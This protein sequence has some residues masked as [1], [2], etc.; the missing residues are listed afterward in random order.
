MDN[1]RRA[2]REEKQRNIQC[3][4]RNEKLKGRFGPNEET[5]IMLNVITV[6]TLFNMEA[7]SFILEGEKTAR[8]VLGEDCVSCMNL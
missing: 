8:G 7:D 5:E 4:E 3:G 6:S 1:G 2:G